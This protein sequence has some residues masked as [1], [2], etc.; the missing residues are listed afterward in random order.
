MKAVLSLAF[1]NKERITVEEACVI[2]IGISQAPL[3]YQHIPLT[4]TIK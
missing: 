4:S 1:V 2:T 3:I